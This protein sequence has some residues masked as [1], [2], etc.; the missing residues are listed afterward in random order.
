MDNPGNKVLDAL[1]ERVLHARAEFDSRLSERGERFPAEEFDKLWLAI[2]E[3]TTQMK[4][5]R[6]LHRDVAREFSGFREY[7]QL[8][9]EL[10]ANFG[11][12]GLG[13]VS[14]V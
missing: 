11:D 2:L 9:L 8:E 5:R 4:N 6:W 3:Y 13:G 10:T 14:W 1:A 7:L 12:G